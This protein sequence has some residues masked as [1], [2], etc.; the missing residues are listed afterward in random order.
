LEKRFHHDPH[1]KPGNFPVNVWPQTL[2]LCI[3]GCLLLLAE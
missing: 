1:I 2:G 3:R